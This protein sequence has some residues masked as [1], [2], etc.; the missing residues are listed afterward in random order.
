VDSVGLGAGDLL[1]GDDAAGTAAVFHHDGLAEQRAH[2]VG[3][4]PRHRV[5]AAAGREADHQPHR[6]I[7]LRG[8]RNGGEQKQAAKD[9][10]RVCY[11]SH[12]RALPL[13]AGRSLTAV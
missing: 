8:G 11:P 12:R 13:T 7:V 10:N 3:E 6:A 9:A 5:D 4:Q 1:A 2:L